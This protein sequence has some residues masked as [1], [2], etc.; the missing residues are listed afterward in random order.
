MDFSSWSSTTIQTTR[1]NSGKIS[2]EFTI[3]EESSS[4][5]SA[6]TRRSNTYTRNTRRLRPVGTF[7]YS[8]STRIKRTKSRAW[9]LLIWSEISKK[10]RKMKKTKRMKQRMIL[11]NNHPAREEESI[12]PLKFRRWKMRSTSSTENATRSREFC[13]CRLQRHCL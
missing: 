12:G 7:L 2:N 6:R 9:S 5:N 11:R 10:M 4:K 8:K 13:S 1:V 3:L